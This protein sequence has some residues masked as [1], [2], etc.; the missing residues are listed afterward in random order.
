MGSNVLN[1]NRFRRYFRSDLRAAVSNYGITFLVFS[2]LA[3]TAY[4]LHG[5]FFLTTSGEWYAMS[6]SLRIALFVISG[7]TV[8]ISS[9]AK[10][11]GHLTD[12]REGSAFLMVPVSRLE[13]FVSMVLISCIII[14][15]SFGLIYL[16]LDSLVCLIGPACGDS[17]FQIIFKSSPS[18][19]N[20]IPDLHIYKESFRSILTPWL[21][22]DDIIQIALLFLLGALIFKKSKTGKTLGS[23]I[24]ISISLKLL[25]TPI[26]SL[27]MFDKFRM[28][29]EMM[30]DANITLEAIE[31]MFPFF[32]WVLRNLAILDTISD[33]LMNGLLMFFV[34]LRLKKLKH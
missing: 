17:L 8:L 22:F 27:A 26:M 15:F 10:L 13:K 28:M 11:Y 16:T 32:S 12:R 5:L 4:L 31:Q 23:L 29:A 14:P 2:T 6:S 24:I 21:Y 25:F 9:P 3:V 30:S 34:W 33:T 20:T 1:M 7:L 19:I 18:F